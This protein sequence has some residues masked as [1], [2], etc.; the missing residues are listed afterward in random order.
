M[1]NGTIMTQNNHREE[2]LLDFAMATARQAGSLLMSYFQRELQIQWK[3]SINL[4][5]EADLA[6]EQ[7]IVQAIRQSYPEHQYLCEEGNRRQTSSPY[8]WIVDPLDGTTN[9]AHG[10]PCF[11]VTIALERGG[12][13]LLGAV[14]NPV[15]GEMFH[16]LRGGGA[17]LNGKAIRVSAAVDMKKSLL[18][19]GFPYDVETNPD[20]NMELFRRFTMQA[21][22]VRRDGSAALDLCYVACGRF[23]GF[24]E[25]SLAAWDAAAG[26]LMIEEAGG[27][28]S[29]YRGDRFDLFS[30]QLVAANR[31]IHSAMIEVIRT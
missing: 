30:G 11:N 4:V 20:N 3:G 2:E 26:A 13:I 21:Q 18:V 8:R 1:H 29:D 25:K 19:T 28:T 15:L 10:Y 12:E 7:L 14:Y 27:I 9:F 23:D 16:A 22:A 6:S 5:T 24:W 17:F 31:T